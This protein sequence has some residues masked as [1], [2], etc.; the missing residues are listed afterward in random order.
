MKTTAA[1]G[2][3][4]PGVVGRRSTRC[5]TVSAV[6]LA[7]G[8]ALVALLAAYLVGG[9]ARSGWAEPGA[10]KE[11]D[12]KA[13]FLMH[14]T[15][16]VEWPETAFPATDTPITIGV[17]GENVFGDAL[18]RAVET[19]S[20]RNRKLVVKQG[21]RMD[22]LKTCHVLFVSRSQQ[23]QIPEVLATLRDSS[24]LTVGETE[25]FAAQGGV[26][27]FYLDGNKVRFEINPEAARRH[28]LKISAQLL[29]L[30]KIVTPEPLKENP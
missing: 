28:R 29:S 14:F 19:A 21:L 27:N 4:V 3:A 20:V 7:G 15:E 17:L 8:R 5:P 16:F 26:I 2:G 13:A 1:W 24:V 12:V 11:Y 6:G 9:H 25:G 30:G 10:F 22:E 18:V 23:S